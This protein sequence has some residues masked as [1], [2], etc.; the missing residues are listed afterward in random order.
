MA[1]VRT[2]HSDTMAS[3]SSVSLNQMSASL[4]GSGSFIFASG[5]VNPLVTRL[6][7][8]SGDQILKD[9]QGAYIKFR[10]GLPG[11][12]RASCSYRGFR[13]G[14]FS[15]T[16]GLAQ[17]LRQGVW[18]WESRGCSGKCEGLDKQLTC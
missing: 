9:L 6:P 3:S 17:R 13:V 10:E 2:R 7:L 11:G 18:G 14:P 5:V 15:K 12:Y 1:Q 4:Y 16:W 8:S